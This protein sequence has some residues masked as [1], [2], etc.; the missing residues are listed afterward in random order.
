MEAIIEGLLN[1]GMGGIIIAI[2]LYYLNK[3]TTIHREE[4]KEWAEANNRHVENFSEVIKEN[5]K[6][7]TEMRSDV[8][9][10]KCKVT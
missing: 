7:L 9:E 2:L 4:R 6:A 3:L 5:T 1:Y 10:N 8:K